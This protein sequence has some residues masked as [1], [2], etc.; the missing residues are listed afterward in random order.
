MEMISSYNLHIP[1]D[2]LI[3]VCNEA[4]VIEGVIKEWL[5]EIAKLPIGSKLIIEDAASTDGTVEILRKYSDHPS[6]SIKLH[7]ERDGFSEALKRL[8]EYAENPLI[9]VADSDGQYLIDDF[10]FFVYKYQ[11][12]IDFVKGVKVSRRD[13]WPRRTFSFI[14]NRFISIFLNLPPYDYNSSHYLI[15]KQLLNEISAKGWKFRS[16][17]NVEIGIKAIL[18]NCNYS[19]VYVRHMS[20]TSG[21]SRANSPHRYLKHGFIT[22]QDIWALKNGF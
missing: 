16:Q 10:K 7:Q 13:S 21:F 9:F 15:S 11:H 2:I 20:R 12:G 14:F 18:S 3:P 22:M 17:I 5:D 4:H 19:V 6:C 8:F 1:I